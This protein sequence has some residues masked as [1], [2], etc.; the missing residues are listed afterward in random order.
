MPVDDRTRAQ[1][2]LILNGHPGAAA[3]P[4]PDR[5]DDIDDFDYLYREYAILARTQDA[6]EVAAGLRQILDQ[7]GYGNVPEGEAREIRRETV[8][9]GLVRLT[10]PATPT[11]VPDLIGRL[12][13]V[14]GR[15][16]ARPDHKVYV[17][18]NSCPATEPIEVPSGTTEPVPPPSSD[19][20]NDGDGVSVSIVDTGL[21]PNS[22]TGH[23]WLAGVRGRMENPY[24]FT[25]DDGE[26]VIAPYAGHGTFVAGVLR[27]M[28]P[29]ASVFVERAFNI[30][31]ADYET[32]LA[33]SLEDALDRNPDILVFTFTSAT[34]RDQS[35]HTFDELY[36]RRIRGIK[37]L[38][39]LA[40]AGNDG[41]SRPMWP[42]A[43]PGVIAVG[44]L[45][46][47]GRDRADFS[48]FGGW[49][50]VY[51]PGEDLINAFPEGTYVCS[52]PPVGEHRQFH[53]MAV[54]SGTSFS[55]PVVAGLIAARMSQTGENGQQAADALLRF[56]R[57]QAVP[58]VGAVLYPGQA[59]GEASR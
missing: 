41:S 15:G 11:L 21:I 37:G 36:E 30:A 33:S 49:V 7:A 50:D 10:V 6:E 53:G 45:A 14:L 38:V 57:S 3:H 29:K 17:C 56:A 32:N 23:P 22:A 55:T 44:A 27:C 26:T 54:W 13:E 18:P 8:S 43:H 51:A 46:A 24:V 16:V 31:G 4:A 19:A 20:G 34:H 35:L 5:W 25:D 1:A 2:Q 48:G 9:R 40:P 59:S 47:N 42:A 58:G 52:E 39:V 12:D 28:A